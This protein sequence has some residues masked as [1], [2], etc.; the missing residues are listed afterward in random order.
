MKE[1]IDMAAI[2]KEDT[3]VLFNAIGISTFVCNNKEEADKIIFDLTNKSCRIIYI[4]EELYESIPETLDKYEKS[5][6]PIIIP[7]PEGTTSK[8]IG[9]R[10]IKNNVEKA[11]GIDIF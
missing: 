3:I 11:I 1:R 6:F 5:T 10:K 9:L 8:G 2:G 4:G 7:I